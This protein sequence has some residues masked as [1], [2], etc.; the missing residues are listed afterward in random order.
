MATTTET[1]EASDLTAALN[2]SLDR[3]IADDFRSPLEE[4]LDIFHKGVEENFRSESSPDGVSWAPRKYAGDG[5]PLLF[6]TGAMFKEAMFGTLNF[7]DKAAR[8]IIDREDV[9]Y[10][11][12]HNFGFPE[13]NIP[14]REFFGASE[15]RL[16]EMDPVIADYG[17]EFF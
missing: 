3:M 14:Q 11:G 17:L 9:P 5:H 1:I 4:M 7:A 6:L 2:T 10:A 12:V 8:Q 15:E 16:K 13:R